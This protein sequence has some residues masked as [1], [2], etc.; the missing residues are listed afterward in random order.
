MKWLWIVL[1]SLA[2]LIAVVVM[3][4][5]MLPVNHV[6]SRRARF[7]ETPEQ[8]WPSLSP[9][10]S[11]QRFRQDDVNY[12]V[13]EATPNR[14]LVTQITDKNLPYG[15]SWIYEI[16]PEATGSILRITERGDV[17]NP[18]FRFISRFVMGH[19]A[20]IDTSLRALGKKLG[21]DVHIE[22]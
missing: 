17:Y 4:G 8:I 10:V 16:E 9:G 21:E 12:E 1:G 18:F 11:Q 7:R 22:N 13:V 14:R 19:T 2:G 20:T 5:A 3:I 15:G 6:A